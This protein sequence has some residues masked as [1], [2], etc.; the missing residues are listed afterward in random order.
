MYAPNR[1]PARDQF[2]DD[3]I[4]KID[5]SVL[6]GDFNAVFDRLLDRV[7]S[8]PDDTLRESSL[9]LYHLF[10]SRCVEDVWCYLHPSPSSF[11]WARW[12]HSCASCGWF[13]GC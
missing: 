1:N 12:D 3:L 2:F 11:T 8:S 10:N 7:G 5:P 4:P 9:A 13:F 6:H